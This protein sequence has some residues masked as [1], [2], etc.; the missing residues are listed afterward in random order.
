MVLGVG[1]HAPWAEVL[2][3]YKHLF[4]VNQKHGSFYLQ[5]KVYRAWEA[6]DEEY[7]RRGLKP[8]GAEGGDAAAGGAAAGQEGAEQQ[9]GQQQGQQQQQQEQR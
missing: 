3:R 1:E 9:Q 8:P 6:L 5:S 4:D 2:K 7:T